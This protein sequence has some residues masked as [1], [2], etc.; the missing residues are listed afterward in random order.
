MKALKCHFLQRAELMI[1]SLGTDRLVL[2]GM[3][4]LSLLYLTPMLG[5]G[6]MRTHMWRQADCLS[7]THHYYTG[8]PFLEPE[9]HIQLGHNYTTGKSAGEFPVLYYMVAGFWKVFGKS[10]LSFRL[11]YLIIFLAGIWSFYRSLTLLFGSKFWPAWIS[12]LM[13]TSPIYVYYGVSFLTDVPAFSFVLMAL[14]SLLMYRLKGQIGWFVGSILL[15]ALAGLL[16]VSSLIAFVFLAFVFCMEVLGIKTLGREKLF[17]KPLREVFGLLMV[18]VLIVAWYYYAHLYNVQSDFKYTF[19]S[20]HPFW[21]GTTEEMQ[22]FGEMFEMYTFSSIY[23]V[24]VLALLLVALIYNLFRF[25]QLSWLARFSTTVIPF[26]GTLYFFLWLPLM[27]HHDYYYIAL[28][29]LVPAILLPT[30]FQLRHHHSKVLMQKP[31]RYAAIGFLA[32]NMLYC[33]AVVHLQSDYKNWS[34]VLITNK[35]FLQIRDFFNWE[36]EIN[37]SRLTRMES[38]LIEL[39]IDQGARVVVLPDES[40]NITLYLL[41][42]K[43]W[44]GREMFQT[45]EDFE[46]LKQRGA[47]HLIIIDDNLLN[48]PYLQ[49]FLNNQIGDFEGVRIFRF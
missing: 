17:K 6:M 21:K 24:S 14:Y 36:R 20:I 47:T 49:P 45:V 7:I 48:A 44:T 39:G 32:F 46:R 37:L 35:P 8:N 41:N 33:M 27:S 5:E 40:F 4:L 25:R 18:P 23:H 2:A 30:L 15:F 10:Y 22:R 34:R 11:F 42:R 29:I 31:M 26:G 43:G 12:F 9:M 16:K 38:H 19:N 1:E 28:L 3:V 13:L